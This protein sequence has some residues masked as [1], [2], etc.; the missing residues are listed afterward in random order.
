MQTDA[1]LVAAATAGDRAAFERLYTRYAA[2]LTGFVARQVGDR[3]LAED[4]VQD[5]FLIAWRDLDRLR[6]PAAVRSWLYGIA[7]HR[8]LDEGRRPGPLPVAELPERADPAASPAAVAEQREAAGL[9]WAAAQGLEPRQRAVLEL[10][11][12]A[13]LSSAEIGGVLGV[14]RAHA[15]VLVHRTRSALGNAV[16]TLLVARQRGRCQQLDAL[17]G[18]ARRVLSARQRSSVDHHIRRCARCRRLGGLVGRSALLVAAY[19]L[20]DGLTDGLGGDGGGPATTPLALRTDPPGRPRARLVPVA[21]VA[22]VLATGFATYALWP[23]PPG[24]AAAEPP[25]AAAS[26]SVPVPVTS[27]SAPVVTTSTPPPT[28]S[29]SPAP[30]TRPPSATTTTPATSATSAAA[31]KPSTSE[32]TAEEGQVLTMV[33][34]ERAK[35]GC[36]PLRADARLHAAALAH[37]QDMAR[38]DFFDHVN[39]DGE[40]ADA[41]MA[42]AGYSW[43]MWGE[44]IAYGQP[45]AKDVMASWMNSPAHR[46]NILNCAFTDLGVAMVSNGS[47]RSPLWTQV[48]GTP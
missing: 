46:D 26:T 30:T 12:R 9:V 31:A 18:G 37:S 36:Q 21:A 32:D 27:A 8:V 2:P 11:V 13:G 40:H 17:V 35:A 39:P 5:C 43:S 29:S 44:N 24:N 7:Y 42:R 28:T 20:A 45:T 47:G 3:H 16:R 38:R 6:D 34:A 23:E 41:R 22:L 19:A 1:S 14:G 48:F 33:N 4:I 10:S 25:A 15:S